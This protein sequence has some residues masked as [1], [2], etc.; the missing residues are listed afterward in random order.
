MEPWQKEHIRQNLPELVRTTDF[1]AYVIALLRAKDIISD[2]EAEHL[3]SFPASQSSSSWDSLASFMGSLLP[4]NYL[5]YETNLK[6]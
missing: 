4:W 1:N 3:V 6:L 2:H 5:T